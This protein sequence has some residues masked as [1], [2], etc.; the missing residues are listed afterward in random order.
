MPAQ[1]TLVINLNQI[2]ENTQIL[3]ALM[4]SIQI[5]GVTKATC[6]S[7]EVAAAMLKGGATAIGDSRLENIE[8]MREAGIE[9]PMWLLRASTHGLA[10]ETVRLADISLASEYDL[11]KSLERACKRQDKRHRI[12]PMVDL[13]DRREGMMPSELS[14]FLDLIS[15]FEHIDVAGIGVSLTCFAGVVPDATNLGE[16]VEL[17]AAA[18]ERLT[19]E[20]EEKEEGAE[21]PERHEE[22]EWFVSGG[23]SSSIHAAITGTMPEGINSL[24][25]GESILLGVDTLTRQAYT[26]LYTE[27]ITLQAP[28]IEVKQKPSAPKGEIAQDAFGG[29]PEFEDRG[30]RWRAILAIGRQ[31]VDPDGITA[32]DQRIK[33][34]GAS[35]DQTIVDVDILPRTPVV[36]EWV[37]FVPDYSAMLRLFTSPYV[38]KE[39]RS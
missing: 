9:A 3:Q 33:V 19:R 1:A 37:P 20:P 25:I 34:L 6:G 10:D 36:G 16:L 17:A 21:V 8:R 35:S 31:D 15:K 18:K 28:M 14:N 12:I 5:V 32:L 13:G 27:A 2:T 23:N 22:P 39:F 38:K 11:V 29:R 4:P 30:D 7:P 24:R 26:G